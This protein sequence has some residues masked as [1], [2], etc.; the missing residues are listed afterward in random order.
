MN[1]KYSSDTSGL[2]ANIDTIN[3]SYAI[4]VQLTGI[5]K[6]INSFANSMIEPLFK[7]QPIKLPY[8]WP[9]ITSTLKMLDSCIK[10][11][12]VN[13]NIEQNHSQAAHQEQFD[14]TYEICDAFF[15]NSGFPI[16]DGHMIKCCNQFNSRY[17]KLL[18]YLNDHKNSLTLY[19]DLKNNKIVKNKEDY[20]ELKKEVRRQLNKNGLEIV[21]TTVSGLGI[22]FIGIY[23]K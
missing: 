18:W 23:K 8:V 20:N 21:Y 15:D 5:T 14:E 3:N 6:I 10:S 19:D 1:K 16:L 13:L 9:N 7:S 22:K 4:G 12:S 17:G 2:L 11:P